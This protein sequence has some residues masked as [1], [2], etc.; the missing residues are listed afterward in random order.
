MYRLMLLFIG[1]VIGSG[2]FTCMIM[3][4]VE[5]RK[6][7][8]TMLALGISPIKLAAL[9]SLEALSIS[10]LGCFIGTLIFI[11]L[12]FYIQRRELI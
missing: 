10:T 11:P 9:L 12:Y 3:N 5:R 7:I 2:I 4:V 6:E 1:L 8:G